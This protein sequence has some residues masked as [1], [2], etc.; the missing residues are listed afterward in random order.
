MRKEPL[1]DMQR[2]ELVMN[3]DVCPY[4]RQMTSA[5][6]RWRAGMKFCHPFTAIVLTLSCGISSDTWNA[7][8]GMAVRVYHLCYATCQMESFSVSPSKKAA[9]TVLTD[10][11]WKQ[12]D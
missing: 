1:P 9:R 5:S 2:G 8:C 12:G 6:A 3:D 4:S 11:A 10:G 7:P